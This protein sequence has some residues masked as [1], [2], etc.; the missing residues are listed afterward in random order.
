MSQNQSMIIIEFR[1]EVENWVG[2][3]EESRVV[4]RDRRGERRWEGKGDITF[5]GATR[6]TGSHPY[7]K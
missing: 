7:T 5:A 6:K 2:P 4:L 3:E 1:N